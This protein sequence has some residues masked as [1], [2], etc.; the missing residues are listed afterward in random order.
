VQLLECIQLYH[1]TALSK[2]EIK[3]SIVCECVCVCVRVCVHVRVCACVCVCVECVVCVRT[4]VYVRV[5]CWPEMKCAWQDAVYT[6]VDDLLK[7]PEGKLVLQ[8]QSHTHRSAHRYTRTRVCVRKK[9]AE[10]VRMY[11]CIH[12]VL[13]EYSARVFLH[14]CKPFAC[15]CERACA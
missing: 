6:L 15:M 1:K 8:R 11:V 7:L 9:N 4:L 12:Y 5:E 2:P 3:V 14:V 10:F 13:T